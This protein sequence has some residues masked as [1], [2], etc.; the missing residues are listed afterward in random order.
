MGNGHYSTRTS[1]DPGSGISIALRMDDV[2]CEITVPKET[3][4]WVAISTRTVYGWYL[5]DLG[6]HTFIFRGG[7]LTH[8]SNSSKSDH[9][10]GWVVMG[11]GGMMPMCIPRF[12]SCGKRNCISDSADLGPSTSLP[13]PVRIIFYK[14]TIIAKP[15]LF[16][17]AE[18]N[19]NNER[20]RSQ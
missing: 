7:S 2:R 20:A 4:N 6:L 19:E 8:A 5:N 10:L 17:L 14:Q 11:N 3:W 12:K 9:V 1:K 13:C 15:S 16:V 18:E